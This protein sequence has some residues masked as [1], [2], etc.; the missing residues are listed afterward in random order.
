MAASALMEELQTPSV[1][2]QAHSP[3]SLLQCLA[4]CFTAKLIN[5]QL[6]KK[7]YVGVR[8]KEKRSEG[9]RGRKLHTADLIIC[10]V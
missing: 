9:R 8:R 7:S 4:Q 10:K 3:V 5:E 6:I 1:L 2:V